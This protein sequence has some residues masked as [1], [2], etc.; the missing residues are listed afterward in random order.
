MSV[1][2]VATSK[3]ESVSLETFPAV[4]SQGTQNNVQLDNS[5][6][7]GYHCLVS[8]A[9][10]QLVVWNLGTPGDTL[11]NGSRVTKAMI[12]PGDTL[13]LGGTEFQVNYK[14]RMRRYLYGVRS[15]SR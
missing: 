12:K 13:A 4:I 11:V 10:G 3:S 5:M 15:W 1:E 9:D 2:L 6:P 14:P 8:L 7:S